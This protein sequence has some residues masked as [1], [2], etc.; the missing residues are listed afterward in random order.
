MASY[1]HHLRHLH[2][3]QLAKLVA[4]Q[5]EAL[6]LTPLKIKSKSSH[7]R[8]L[9]YFQ[10]KVNECSEKIVQVF[11]SSIIGDDIPVIP[12]R[13]KGELCYPSDDTKRLMLQLKDRCTKLKE[14]KK[15]RRNSL[16][17]DF[18]IGL[19][20]HSRNSKFFSSYC[21]SSSAIE[22]LKRRKWNTVN[23]EPKEIKKSR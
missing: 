8:K 7:A 6:D 12:A 11:Q 21:E 19:M 10:V 3:T 22:N 4:G 20:V 17:V 14:K 2:S 9:D 15:T 23:S 18:G 13:N 16:L 1:S 5:L